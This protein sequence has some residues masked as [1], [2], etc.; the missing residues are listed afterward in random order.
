MH[1]GS[2]LEEMGVPSIAICSE[3]FFSAGKV[4]ARVLGYNDLEPLT[5]V[6]PIQSLTSKQIQ[7]RADSVVDKIIERLIK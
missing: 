3:V 4:Q 2:V 6:H 7:E 5:V 1:D